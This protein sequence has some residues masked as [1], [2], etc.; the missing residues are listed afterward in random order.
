MS[1]FITFDYNPGGSLLE[2]STDFGDVWQR[3]TLD[4]LWGWGLVRLAV[5]DTQNI[6]VSGDYIAKWNVSNNQ[7]DSLTYLSLGYRKGEIYFCDTLNG[8]ASGDYSGNSCFYKTV[9]G[10]YAWDSVSTLAYLTKFICRGVNNIWAI[11]GGRINYSSDSGRTWQEQNTGITININCIFALNDSELWAGA[12]SGFIIYTIDGGAN[13]SKDSLNTTSRVNSIF[14]TGDS[15]GWAATSNGGL[16]GFGRAGLGVEGTR[17][18]IVATTKKIFLQASPN[19]FRQN[20]T[21][22]F[23]QNSTG[24]VN[25]SIYSITGQLVKT[26]VDGMQ[27]LGAH[28]IS[29][30][31]CDNSNQKVSQ[32]VYICQMKSAKHLATKKIVLLR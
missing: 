31:G 11:C 18:E 14:F 19:P 13:W 17:P 2:Y 23:E 32:G 22:A 24:P 15:F 9:D 27:G 20:T 30:N 26:L 21:I 8:F 10:G 12:D 5:V 25:V 7:W 3:R 6:W 16:W 1:H 29:W 4:G 28:R